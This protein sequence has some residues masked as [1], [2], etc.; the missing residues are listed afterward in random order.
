MGV[1]QALD[2]QLTNMIAA[3]EVVERPMGIV[4]EL[5]ENAID[6]KATRIDILVQQGGIQSIQIVDNGLGMDSVD[7]TMAFERHATSKISKT[8]DLWS[9][10]TLGFRGEALPSI[11]SV[12]EVKLETNNGSESTRVEIQY[13]QLISARPYPCNQGTM[14]HISG[15]FQK[16]PARLKHLK[17]VAYENSLISDVVQKFALSHPEIAFS[18]TSDSK[19]TF[20][21]S[22]SN[23]LLEVVFQLYGKDVAKNSILIDDG[24]TDYKVRGVCVH[25]QFTRATRNAISVFLN[26]RMVRPY[27]IQKAIIDSY[28][29]YIPSDRYPIVI[30]NVTMDSQL[31]DVNVHPSKWE[32]RLSKEQQLEHLLR[33]IIPNAIHSHI[34]APIVN[35]EKVVKEKIEIQSLFENNDQPIQRVFKEEPV[36]Y[37]APR[38]MSEVE[39]DL[40][41][42]IGIEE[43]IVQ[44]PMQQQEEK[45]EPLQKKSFPVLK[46]IGQMHGKYILC[47]GVEGLYIIDQHAAQERVHY[48][49]FLNEMDQLKH[50]MTECLVPHMIHSTNDLVRRI[51]EIN[52]AVKDLGLEF[53]VFGDDSFVVREI[54]IWMK[55]VEEGVFLQ[56]LIDSFK[57]EKEI[58]KNKIHKHKIATMACHHSIR[59]NRILNETEMNE[60]VSQLEKCEQPYHCP[61][62]RPTF[63]CL[64][65]SRLEKEFYR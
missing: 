45:I 63:I 3:G 27:R 15:L 2:I 18:F 4:K 25:P 43:K 26:G 51:D 21:T 42:S 46:V 55:E 6:A 22:G 16:T 50:I 32:V 58:T 36:Q 34:Q 7:A 56:D 31:V 24:D 30:L 19:Q 64:D 28:T 48:E 44:A 38:V 61:H 33:E 41:S 52:L 57:D 8:Q 17:T 35:M 29:N 11:A 59:F 54:P 37:V 39:N 60:V 40:P 47:E 10:K 5:V 23:D 1:I 13:G 20:K 9:I 12:S 62:G 49:K 53:E 65:A 14:I